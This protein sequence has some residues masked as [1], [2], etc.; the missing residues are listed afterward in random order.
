MLGRAAYQYRFTVTLGL[1]DNK[2]IDLNAIRT[3]IDA[4]K[5]NSHCRHLADKAEGLRRRPEGA[6]KSDGA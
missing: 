3:I 6:Q 2:E 4:Q 1:D 5:S